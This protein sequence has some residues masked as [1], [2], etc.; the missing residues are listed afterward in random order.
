LTIESADFHGLLNCLVQYGDLWS[1]P[2]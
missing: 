1:M 2:I